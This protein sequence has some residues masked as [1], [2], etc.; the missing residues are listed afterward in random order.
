MALNS[1]TVNGISIDDL[2]SS[3]KSKPE[4]W[5]SNRKDHKW[6]STMFALGCAC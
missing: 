5:S 2:S 4:A 3:P 6:S 1:E